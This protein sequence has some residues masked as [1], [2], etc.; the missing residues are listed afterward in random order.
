MRNGVVFYIQ[1]YQKDPG[2]SLDVVEKSGVRSGGSV[3]EL[4]DLHILETI[5]RSGGNISK[6]AEQLELSRTTLYRVLH[7]QR[8]AP[9][10][11]RSPPTLMLPG[12]APSLPHVMHSHTCI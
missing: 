4:S 1:S 9:G 10:A 11:D 8:P 5:K 7:R 6:A 2:A 12:S 3:R